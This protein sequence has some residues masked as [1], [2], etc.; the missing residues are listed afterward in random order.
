MEWYVEG[1]ISELLHGLL[2]LMDCRNC[3]LEF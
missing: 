2:E 1:D 3:R